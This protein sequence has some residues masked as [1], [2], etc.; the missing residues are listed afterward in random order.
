VR[1]SL[2]AA[3]LLLVLLLSRPVGAAPGSARFV[4]PDRVV[5]GEP[6]LVE[7]L[8]PFEPDRAEL[9]WLG[10]SQPLRAEPLADGLWR[11]RA[12]AGTTASHP[13]GKEIVAFR[14]E[15]DGRTW[16]FPWQI[17][18]GAKAFPESRLT[19]P[20]KMV[21]PPDEV[22]SRIEAEGRR[23]AQALAR[24][25]EEILWALPLHRPVKG[26][27]TCP[28]GWRRVYNGK[29]RSPHS[30]VDLRAAVGTPVGAVAAGVVVLAEEHYFA[31]NVVYVD[32]GGG[33]LSAYGHLSRI[34]VG[35]GQPVKA[36]QTVGLAGA[37]GRVTGP[38]LHLG[39]FLQGRHADAVP[40]FEAD[41]KALLEGR[42]GLEVSLR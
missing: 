37:T 29:P 2:I 19:V 9:R 33:V 10:R 26:I 21:V 28:Y 36:G 35:P 24:S 39:L 15:A 42:E 4:A 40:L 1:R 14:V 18:I 30:G 3:V 5:Q 20:E 7:L 41:E 16:S 32:H 8:L 31:G 25:Q 17:E 12:L 23:V 27:V 34:D 22:R 38:H 13:A 6:F 11:L